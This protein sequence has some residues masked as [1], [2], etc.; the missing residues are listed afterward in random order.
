MN[1]ASVTVSAMNQGL[2]PATRWGA[3]ASSVDVW[4]ARSASTV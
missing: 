2:I 1:V 3:K 4:D